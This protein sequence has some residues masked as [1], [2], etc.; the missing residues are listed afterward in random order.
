M[1]LVCNG[2]NGICSVA[3][4][5]NISDLGAKGDGLTLN[6]NIIQ[7]AIDS[8]AKKGGGKVIVPKGRFLTGSIE[9]K[10]GV[11]LQITEGGVLLGS[12]WRDDY[13]KN[14]WFAL[15]LVKNQKNI[16][17][18]RLKNLLQREVEQMVRKNRTRQKFMERLNALLHEYNSGSK[19]K[20]AK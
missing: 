10:T 6:T 12:A 18:E 19:D 14:D 9:L 11:T 3:T 8:C 17:I 2:R 20:E 1:C 13:K 7:F 16:A 15:I 5:V 4:I